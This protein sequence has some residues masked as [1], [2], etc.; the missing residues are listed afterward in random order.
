VPGHIDTE[1]DWSQYGPRD[2]WIASR[3]QHIPAQRMGKV[4][5]VAEACVYLASPAAGFVTGQ[6]IHVNGGHYMY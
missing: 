3:I 5:E 2:E 4:D 6:A 1:R